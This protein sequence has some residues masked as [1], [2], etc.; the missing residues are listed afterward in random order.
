MPALVGDSI[1][2][3]SIGFKR[4][5]YVVPEHKAENS[6]RLILYLQQDVTYLQEVEI[7]PYPSEAT[8]KAAVLAA[9]LPNQQDLDNLDQWL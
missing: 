1:V 9:E 5:Y 3:S 4:T 2:F 7:F 8:F 6:L